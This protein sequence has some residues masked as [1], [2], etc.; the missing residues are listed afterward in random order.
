[1]LVD[2]PVAAVQRSG[3][4]VELNLDIAADLEYLPDHFPGYPMLPGVVQLGWAVR[5]AQREL[6]ITGPLRRV[7]ALKF[8]QPIRHG[9]ALTL[10]LERQPGAAVSFSYRSG[11][12]VL[13]GGRLHFGD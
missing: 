7:A 5:S 10:R 1:M 4:T 9:T 13:S 6:G 3:E 11:D 8:M 2:P 12:A